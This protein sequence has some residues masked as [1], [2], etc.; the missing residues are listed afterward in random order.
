MT[1]RW[2]PCYTLSKP[3][4]ACGT[5]PPP[6]EMKRDAT[7]VLIL[8]T[9]RIIDLNDLHISADYVILPSAPPPRWKPLIPSLH[10]PPT[11][12]PTAFT[13]LLFISDVPK[14]HTWRGAEFRTLKY[15]EFVDALCSLPDLESLSLRRAVWLKRVFAEE[16]VRR[17][18]GEQGLRR[19]NFTACGMTPRSSWTKKWVARRN[20]S[21]RSLI[22]FD[23]ST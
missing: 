12:H 23:S 9:S 3:A 4:L 19:V 18:G 11:Y 13:N 17:A 21:I 8:F 6:F 5:S 10:K 22:I 20:E 2:V 16:I 1:F 7:V 14:S 15:E